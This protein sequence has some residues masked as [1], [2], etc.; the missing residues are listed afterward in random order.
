MD[1]LEGLDAYEVSWKSESWIVSFGK[2]RLISAFLP[3]FHFYLV[4]QDKV[5]G[6]L[7]CSQSCYATKDDLALLHAPTST[8]KVLGLQ[9]VPPCLAVGCWGGAQGFRML[10][11]SIRPLNCIPAHLGFLLNFKILL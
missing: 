2:E 8:T 1:Q 3:F 11:S 4:F 10:G 5:L 9:H 7:G 6:N